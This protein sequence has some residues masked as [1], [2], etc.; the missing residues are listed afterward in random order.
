[1]ARVIFLSALERG[2]FQSYPLLTPNHEMS[3][4]ICLGKDFANQA[5]FM[6]VVFL[7]WAF[8]IR[9]AEDADGQPILPSRDD[10]V[11][12]GLVV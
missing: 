11:D 4:R 7:L 6:N 8:D 9:P 2:V 10:L 1:M 3:F 5:L 12:D